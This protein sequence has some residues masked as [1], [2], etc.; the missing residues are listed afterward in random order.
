M[1]LIYHITPRAAWQRAQQ[2]GEYRAASL[3][4]EGFIHCSGR[5][6]VVRVAKEVLQAL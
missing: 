2:R 3:R 5:T 4:R 1:T 6:Q